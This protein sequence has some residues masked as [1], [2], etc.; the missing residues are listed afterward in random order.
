MSSL[1]CLANSCEG[2]PT[3]GK[4]AGTRLVAGTCRCVL[5]VARSGFANRGCAISASAQAHIMQREVAR[6]QAGAAR[7]GLPWLEGEI[8]AKRKEDIT[9]LRQLQ[10]RQFA[11]GR[12]LSKDELA[13]AVA[14]ADSAGHAQT[15]YGFVRVWLG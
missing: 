6:L 12:R 7:H 1:T 10:V 14:E 4:I 5:L 13:A 9:A 15:S 8:A 11:D 3:G 2:G